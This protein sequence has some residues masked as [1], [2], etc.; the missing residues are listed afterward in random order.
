[1]HAQIALLNGKIYTVDEHRPWAQAVAIQDG[2]FIAVGSTEEVQRLVGP[3]TRAVDLGGRFAMPGIYDMHT[4]PD[5]ALGP[6]YAGQFDVTGDPTPAQLADAI[7]EYAAQHPGEGWICG[8]QFVW[9]TFR[10]QRLTPNRWWLDEVMPDR[11]VAIHDRSWGC[12]LANSKALT[13]AGINASTRDPGNGYIERDPLTG[14]P[15]GILVDGAYSL[16]YRVMPPPPAAALERAYGDA[17][18]FQ[19]SRG[20]VGVKFVHVCEH[21]LDALHALDSRGLLTARVEAAISWQDDIFPVRRRW[22]LM[23]G[24]RHHY[25]SRRLNANAIKFHFDG[26]HEARSSYL[27]TPW[28]KDEAWRGHLNLTHEHL[29]DLIIQMD[30]EGIRVIAHCTGDGASDVFLDAIA[31][32]RRRTGTGSVRHQCAHCTLLLERNL[33][34]FAQLGVTAEFSPVG[35]IP[36]PFAY[37]RRDAYGEERMRRAYDFKGVLDAGGIAVMGTDWPVS[38]L[39]PWFGFAGMVSR[40]DPTRADPGVFYGEPIPL[41]AAIRVMTINGAWSMGLEQEAGS[42]TVNKR[43]DMIVLDRNLF[44]VDPRTAIHDTSVELTL[45]DG[46]P[47]WDS[48]G[49]LARLGLA[50]VWA[51]A[52]PQL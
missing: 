34:R 18:H 35:W 20:V 40:Q 32:A 42:I 29:V 52:P 51:K 36:G 46:E 17:L 41:E 37:A 39:D 45:I 43:A 44:D 6:K 25:R 9:Y 3:A 5:L 38:Q 24:A 1:V 14:E 13:L 50:P 33:G 28:K 22:E 12:L 16:V 4:H 30:R 11:P 19:A 48:A 7:R 26:T 47:T 8:K 27:A 23:A 21:R 10:K 2:R 49:L 15:T 31:E